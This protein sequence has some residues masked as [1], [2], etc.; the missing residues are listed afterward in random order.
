LKA[1]SSRRVHDDMVNKES[2]DALGLK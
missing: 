2:L 1:Q